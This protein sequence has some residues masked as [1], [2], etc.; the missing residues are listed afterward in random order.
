V[1]LT[2]FTVSNILAF[3]TS[4]VSVFL[5]RLKNTFSFLMDII[6]SDLSRMGV[7]GG[8]TDTDWIVVTQAGFLA[9]SIIERAGKAGNS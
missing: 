9:P 1:T 8:R 2:I 7:G 4:H 3:S 6:Y 5:Q